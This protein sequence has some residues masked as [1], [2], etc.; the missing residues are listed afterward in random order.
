M[1]W[2]LPI[3]A[4]PVGAVVW[5]IAGGTF[6]SS[7]SHGGPPHGEGCAACKGLDWWWSGLKWYQKLFQT[8]WY[9]AKKIDCIIKKCPT[10]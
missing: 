3:I 5:W 9:W 8:A 2:V 1:W 4:G 10:N 7:G 6:P